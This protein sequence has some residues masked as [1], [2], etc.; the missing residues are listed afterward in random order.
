MSPTLGYALFIMVGAPKQIALL[1][2]TSVT[3]SLL[4]S[5]CRKYILTSNPSDIIPSAMDA[6]IFWVE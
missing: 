2:K 6:A 3:T 4:S 5:S 1:S